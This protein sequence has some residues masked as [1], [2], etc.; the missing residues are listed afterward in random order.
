MKQNT[1]WYDKNPDLKEVFEFIEGL[2]VSIQKIIAQDILQIL[3]NDFGLN[4]DEQINSICKNYNFKCSRWYD[5]DINLFTS[6]EII[7]GFSLELQQKFI[8]KVIATILFIYIQEGA[9]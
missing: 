9:K 6:F 7:K 8:E 4:L 3:M 5:N 2:D 1:R